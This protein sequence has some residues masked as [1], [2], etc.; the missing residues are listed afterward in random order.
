MRKIARL[1]VLCSMATLLSAQQ[2]EFRP[3]AVPL[4]AHDP[5]FSIWSMA[6]R[7]TDDTTRHWTRSGQAL[8]SMVRVDGKTYRVMGREPEQ[9]PSFPQTRLQVLPTRTIYDF[10]GSGIR[11]TLTF[12]TPALP[13]DLEILSRP[14]SYITWE[15][16]SADSRT[17]TVE[18]YF[19]ASSLVDWTVWTAALS[20]SKATFETLIEPIYRYAGETPD[21]VPLADTYG[22][23]DGKHRYGQARPVVGGIFIPMLLEP[24][25]WEKWAHA[26]A[27]GVNP[28]Q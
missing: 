28:D 7:L 5:Y 25:M 24:G 17:H 16:Q 12:L 9:I 18:V 2:K 14:A 13:Q 27:G 4:I 8:T 3:P 21:R 26:E 22:T 20:D 23:V 6:D 19:D 11:I 10:E 15:V 1:L